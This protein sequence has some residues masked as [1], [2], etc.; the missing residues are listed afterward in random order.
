MISSAGGQERTDVNHGQRQAAI[1]GLSSRKRERRGGL[2][3]VLAVAVVLIA[4]ALGVFAIVSARSSSST[5]ATERGPGL[6]QVGLRLPAS[7]KPAF[8]VPTPVQ[9]R[10]SSSHVSYW[11]T[12]VRPVAVRGSPRLESRVVAG[13]ETRTPEDTSNIVLVLRRAKDPSGRLWVGIRLPVLP[14]DTTGW[15]PR[16]ALGVYGAV[17]TRLL[18][19][20][21]RFTATLQRDG[22]TIFEAE[23]GVGQSQWPTPRGEFYIRNKLVSYGSS[24]Y[25][26]LAFGTSARSNVLTDWPAGGFIGIHGT[27]QP[28]LL[29]GAVSHG[30]IR[31][32]NEDILELGRLMPVGTPL[33][34][35]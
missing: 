11:A 22:R 4:A 35:S 3:A 19:D 18:V 9:L 8:T 6:L 31:M 10:D 14:N 16:E 25:G 30:C 2:W 34:I 12:V 29:P 21:E 20:L 24:F 32:R 5:P 13:L 26:P 1:H 15:V 28:E 23:I 33:T 17:R 27:D 7:P